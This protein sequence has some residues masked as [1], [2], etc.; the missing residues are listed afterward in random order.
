MNL[1]IE[2]REKTRNGENPKTRGG[3]A[4]REIGIAVVQ[5]DA[6]DWSTP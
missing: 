6:T 4:F 1:F 5:C 3:K 2:K